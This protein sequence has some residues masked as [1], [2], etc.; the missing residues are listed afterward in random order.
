MIRHR[1]YYGDSKKLSG[2]QGVQRGLNRW[3]SGHFSDSKAILSD[4]IMYIHGIMGLSK[5]IKCTRSEP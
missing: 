5:L 4:T 3:S 2:F 1:E